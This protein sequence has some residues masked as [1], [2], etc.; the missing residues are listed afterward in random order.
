MI[1]N[2]STNAELTSALNAA[3]DGDEIVLTSSSYADFSYRGSGVSDD[4]PAVVI[5]SADP[6]APAEF[7]GTFTLRDVSNVTIEDVEFEAGRLAASFSS[8]WVH[9]RDCSNIV[10]ERVSIEGHIASESEGVDPLDPETTRKDV[11]EGYPYAL[12]LRLQDVDGFELHDSEIFNARTGI[13]INGVSDVVIDNTT[14]HNVREGIDFCDVD[15]LTI[16]N[17]VFENLTG[18]IGMEDPDYDNKIHD[19]ADMIQYWDIGGTTGNHNVTITGNLFQMPEG[20]KTQTIFGAMSDQGAYGVTATNFT[21]TENVII[22]GH[23]NAISL[24]DVDGGIISGN[25]ILANGDDL[26]SSSMPKITLAGTTKNFEVSNN[27]VMSTWKGDTLGLSDEEIAEMNITIEDM[28]FLSIDP[29]DPNYYGALSVSELQDLLGLNPAPDPDE[30]DQKISGTTSND[31]LEGGSGDDTVLLRYGDDTAS[32]NDGADTFVF[33]GRY[34]NSG[35][36]HTITD[37]DFTE[38]DSLVFR[39]FDT[40]RNSTSLTSQSDLES[41]LARDD[42]SATE[43]VDG[44][45]LTLTDASMIEL[46]VTLLL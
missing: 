30:A 36:H 13:A 7:S 19:H 34:H 21:V 11:I 46:Q 14:I 44:V 22:N 20:L 33:D 15:G 28:I 8:S 9:I 32:G 31:T 43:T 12:G 3:Q 27:A 5:R 17:N 38:G 45:E 35:D 25:L 29:A 42:V 16:S 39:F 24:G 37:L 10:L 26:T 6:D 41:F 1:I 23:P 40:E 2:V 18:W 4:A